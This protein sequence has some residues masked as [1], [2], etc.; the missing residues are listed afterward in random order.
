MVISRPQSGVDGDTISAAQ[1]DQPAV[2]ISSDLINDPVLFDHVS[3]VLCVGYTLFYPTHNEQRSFFIDSLRNINDSLTRNLFAKVLIRMTTDSYL[4]ESFAVQGI[5]AKDNSVQFF[6]EVISLLKS[7]ALQAIE[8]VVGPSTAVDA[9]NSDICHYL[10]TLTLMWQNSLLKTISG[11]QLR[12]FRSSTVPSL[13]LVQGAGKVLID[14]AI[15]V[16][17]SSMELLA[18]AYVVTDEETSENNFKLL[19]LLRQSIF[20]QLAFPLYHSFVKFLWRCGHTE[21]DIKQMH[22]I[23]SFL[24]PFTVDMLRAMNDFSSVLKQADPTF[25]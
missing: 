25:D 10:T 6:E 12:S 19:S 9:R 1:S 7:D 11:S 8:S 5:G 22:R 23:T 21:D 2:S 20:G 4:F 18:A 17:N 16:F 15:K 24:Y 3:M 14:Y 13:S